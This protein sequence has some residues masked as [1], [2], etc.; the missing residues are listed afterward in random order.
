MTDFTDIEAAQE[1]AKRFGLERKVPW[2]AMVIG[3]C[4]ERLQIENEMLTGMLRIKN[5]D[6]EDDND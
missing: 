6:V 1:I 2:I 3:K 5:G 4:M